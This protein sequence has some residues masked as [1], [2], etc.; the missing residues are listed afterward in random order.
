MASYMNWHSNQGIWDGQGMYHC[1]GR[2]V[3]YSYSSR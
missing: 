3:G 1:W 2:W